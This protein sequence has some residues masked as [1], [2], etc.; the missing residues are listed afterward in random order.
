MASHRLVDYSTYTN[1]NSLLTECKMDLDD[2]QLDDIHLGDISVNFNDDTKSID[3]DTMSIESDDDTHRNYNLEKDLNKM[4]I[5]DAKPTENT[6]GL[7][8]GEVNQK[9]DLAARISSLRRL[10][11]FTHPPKYKN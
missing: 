11:F 7:I 4:E 8:L 10:Y 3:T 5:Q 1:N 9:K 2:D 6:N